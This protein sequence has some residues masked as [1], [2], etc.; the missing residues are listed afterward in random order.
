MRRRTVALV[1]ALG[2]AAVVGSS[3]AQSGPTAPAGP[4]WATRPQEVPSG[5]TVVPFGIQRDGSQAT[6]WALARSGQGADERLAFVTRRGPSAWSRSDAADALP[7]AV[8]AMVPVGTVRDASGVLTGAPQHAAEMAPNG[9][10]AALVASGVIASGGLHAATIVV[11]DP[12]SRPNTSRRRPAGCRA[13]IPCIACSR[14]RK[15][16]SSAPG[17][18]RR[19]SSRRR[20]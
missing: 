7:A 5:S 10:A 14:S 8:G 9:F 18:R 20:G 1:A 3:L 15:G 2:V 19:G 6:W 16:S 11:T 12:C 13:V 17:H 4:P